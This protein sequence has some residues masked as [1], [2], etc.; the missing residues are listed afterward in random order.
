MCGPE[1]DVIWADE[2]VMWKRSVLACSGTNGG[3]ACAM[4]EGERLGC[5]FFKGSTFMCRK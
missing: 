5:L 3:I 4:K 1:R 2:G